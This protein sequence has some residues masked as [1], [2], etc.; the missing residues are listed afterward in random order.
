MK[1]NAL[2]SKRNIFPRK[3][4]NLK[5]FDLL[6]KRKSPIESVREMK[7]KRNQIQVIFLPK[8]QD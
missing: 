2:I 1:K 4:K 6:A 8:F 3:H 5:F 7:G